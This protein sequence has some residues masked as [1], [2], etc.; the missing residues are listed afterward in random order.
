MAL[1]HKTNFP[2]TK[3]PDLNPDYPSDWHPKTV[4]ALEEMKGVEKNIRLR[5]RAKN[6]DQVAKFEQAIEEGLLTKD[7]EDPYLHS[8]NRLTDDPDKA[9][10]D[11]KTGKP[12]RVQSEFKESLVPGAGFM[13]GDSFWPAFQDALEGH[14]YVTGDPRNVLVKQY[15]DDNMGFAP[16]NYGTGHKIYAGNEAFVLNTHMVDEGLY[17]TDAAN[18]I[19]ANHA[20]RNANIKGDI[21]RGQPENLHRDGSP[22]NNL[23]DKWIY[24]PYR[25][26]LGALGTADPMDRVVEGT[27]RS[28]PHESG[29]MGTLNGFRDNLP[30]STQESLLAFFN[31]NK[32]K[33]KGTW[34]NH[35]TVRPGVD[36][37]QAFEKLQNSAKGYGHYFNIYPE[38]ATVAREAKFDR[39]YGKHGKGAHGRDNTLRGDNRVLDE[40]VTNPKVGDENEE[41]ISNIFKNLNEKQQENF[42]RMWYRLGSNDIKGSLI[43]EGND[44]MA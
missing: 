39:I 8:P 40:I 31:T 12:E 25:R 14:P 37:T 23:T 36:P 2:K 9:A 19:L 15:W 1:P 13:E 4:E 43:E 33:N 17:G 38:M 21:T 30:R 6:Q 41:A 10:V 35:E 34:L 44:V 42:R 5:V 20:K 22:S 3:A 11:T 18:Q 27:V 26:D 7:P 32:N 29:H 24:H 28:L 16:H